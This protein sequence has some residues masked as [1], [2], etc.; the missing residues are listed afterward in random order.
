MLVRHTTR[1]H[2]SNVVTTAPCNVNATAMR[3]RVVTNATLV[4]VRS[5]VLQTRWIKTRVKQMDNF[6]KI[7]GLNL[8]YGSI[9]TVC[10][11]RRF[12]VVCTMS[13]HR[14]RFFLLRTHFGN[15][16]RNISRSKRLTVRQIRRIVPFIADSL[17][18]LLFF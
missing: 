6:R 12:R 5:F 14:S 10:W 13:T 4:L 2:P 7:T 3:S 17:F 9:F 8:H 11:Q 15:A 18:F 1:T 16:E